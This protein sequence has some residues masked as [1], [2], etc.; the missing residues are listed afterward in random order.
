MS[1]K[2]DW[3]KI[4]D[5]QN[6]N[7]KLL[8]IVASVVDDAISISYGGLNGFVRFP[9]G[10]PEE[11]VVFSALRAS[12]FE[13]AIDALAVGVVE[14]GGFDIKD[15]GA[16]ELLKTIGGG[17]MSIGKLREKQGRDKLAEVNKF[18]PKQTHGKGKNKRK[19]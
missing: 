6:D 11:R 7:K 4:Q 17:V 14:S 1:L 12:K 5:W 18:D 2:E 9:P 16:N 3:V 15:K 10:K 8:I 19:K 13:D